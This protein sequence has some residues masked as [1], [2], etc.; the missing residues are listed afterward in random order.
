[1]SDGVVTDE[2][3][4]GLVEVAKHVGLGISDLKSVHQQYFE[5]LFTLVWSDGLLSDPEIDLL[6]EAGRVLGVS[7]IDVEQSI[8]TKT[9][10]SKRPLAEGALV[11]LTGSMNPDKSTISSLLANFGILTT[12]GVSK[13]TTAVIAADTDSMS[14]KANKARQYGIPIYTSTEI[15]R[16]YSE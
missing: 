16:I 14:G 1:M 8:H 2:E 4:Q 5:E 15:W 10:Q 13:K 12:D 6:R 9:G 11:C 7:E 3:V